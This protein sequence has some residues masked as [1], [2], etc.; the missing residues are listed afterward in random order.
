MR[1]PVVYQY[2]QDLTVISGMP[3]SGKTLLAPLISSMKDVEM[4]HMD[5]LIEVFPFLRD[6]NM[7]SSKGQIYLL[8]YAVNLLSY[9][10]SIGR[11]MNARPFDETSIWNAN[12]PQEYLERLSNKDLKEDCIG[13]NTFPLFLLLHNGL[14]YI[15][16]LLTAFDKVKVVNVCSHPIDIVSAWIEK[17]YGK[18]RTYKKK[19]LSVPAF[20]WKDDIVPSYAV[21]WE[22]EYIELNE[23]DRVI[24]MLYRLYL[25]EDDSLSKVHEK[26]KDKL[27]MVSYDK[28]VTNPGL[29]IDRVGNYLGRS[30]TSFTDKVMQKSE[31]IDRKKSI[32]NKDNK[33]DFIKRNASDESIN[34]LNKWIESFTK[35]TFQ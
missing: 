8:Q 20:K 1:T 25:S 18:N 14:T 4:F 12:N 22:D 11:N 15:D 23:T 21:G 26:D 5:A 19:G 24:S 6:C 28:L 31:L 34:K 27:L 33:M 16:T 10:R 3:R 17:E 29:E 2:C 32:L 9:N 7:L 35:I 30:V 13:G